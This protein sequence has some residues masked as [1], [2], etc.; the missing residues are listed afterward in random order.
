MSAPIV[1]VALHLGERARRGPATPAVIVQ[2]HGAYETLTFKELDE[3]SETL[4]RGLIASGIGP[5][6]RTVLMV[7]PGMEFFALVFALFK[8]RTVPVLIDP[9]LGIRN[10]GGCIDE[11]EPAAFIG[12]PKAHAARVLLGWG[13]RTLKHLVTVGPRLLW[14]GR[15]L[16]A[17]RAAGREAPALP[18]GDAQPGDHAAILFTS[19]STGAPKGAVYTHGIFAAQVE[20]LRALYRIEPG[21]R[22]LATFPLFALFG[23][24]LGMTAIVPEM[25]ASRPASADPARLAAAIRDQ[26]AT[27]MFGSPALVNV[28]G[29]YAEAKGLTFPSLKRVIS[30]GAPVPAAVLERMAKALA[31][32][33]QVFTPYGATESLPVAS[34]GSEE[35]LRET[36]ALTEKGKGV[37]VGRP[38]EG[39]KVAIIRIG[40]EPIETWSDDLKLP[41]GET[42]EICVQGPVVTRAYFNKPQAT[43]LA[44][45]PE[46]ESG[47]FW[48]RMGDVGYLDERGRLWMC[49]R[50]SHRV[51]T[52]AGETMFT[53]PCEA[54]FN[55][56]PGVKR[57]ALVGVG[58]R[59]RQ[60]PVL[61]VEAEPTACCGKP[62]EELLRRQLLDMAAQHAHTRAIEVV[63]FHPGFP[64]DIR[65][66]AKIFR[67]K[68]AV[69]AKDRVR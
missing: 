14:G 41:A 18:D 67:E 8:A 63:L 46:G 68:L 59:G 50:K 5:G 69:W 52:A 20:M 39:M 17:I 32:G 19:G 25:D 12:I 37:C 51:V 38:V 60:R 53:I 4:A 26:G 57:S 15:S 42:G 47:A 49:G 65:H 27:N 16:E 33:A 7:K 35:I 28:L 55:T 21:E 43:A 3:A 64:V 61:C 58:E 34:I 48:H 9:G 44:K 40:D 23:P 2:K 66:N 22:D 56:H 1:N 62:A 31:P 45:I 10:L 36:R 54:V 24:A 29:R 11:A 6:T 30:A 13:K